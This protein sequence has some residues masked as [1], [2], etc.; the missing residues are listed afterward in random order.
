MEAKVKQAQ[1]DLEALQDRKIILTR[2]LDLTKAEI[3]T[4]DKQ[5]KAQQELITILNGNTEATDGSADE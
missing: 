5:I 1:T 3:K 2:S 4:V